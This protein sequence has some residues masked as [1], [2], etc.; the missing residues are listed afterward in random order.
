MSQSGRPHSNTSQSRPS[1]RES[2][3]SS[4][5][6]FPT[7]EQL[8]ALAALGDLKR[9]AEGLALRQDVRETRKHTRAV[10]AFQHKSLHPKASVADMEFA[11]ESGAGVLPEDSAAAQ[12]VWELARACHKA[13]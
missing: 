11:G 1:S 3:Q 6:A 5:Q 10:L 4:S 12:I 8:V 9:V 13:S 7:L 2:G